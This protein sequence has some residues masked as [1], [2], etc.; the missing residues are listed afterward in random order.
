MARYQS[1]GSTYFQNQYLTAKNCLIPYINTILPI[2]EKLFV[3]EI[4]CGIGGNLSPFLELG[5]QVYGIDLNSKY[6]QSATK[7]YENNVYKNNLHL[8]ANDIRSLTQNDLP[9]FDLIFLCNA[10]EHIHDQESFLNHLKPFLKPNGL[11]F[12]SFPPWNMP[13]GGHQQICKNKLLSKMPYIHLLPKFLFVAI[14]KLFKEEAQ[15]LLEIRE[16]RVSMKRFYGIIKKLSFY[17][18]K[19]TFYLI[20][21]SYE[22]RFGL[23]PRILPKVLN[24]PYI[25]DFFTTTY[26]SIISLNPKERV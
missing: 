4:G 8:I 17:I 26:Y 23:K 16:T 19:E 2:N 21:P 1:D 10:F 22:I 25:R 3:A 24:I 18:H 13:F 9:Q 11:L 6:I 7:F 14:L 15:N 20:N 12:L 5:C